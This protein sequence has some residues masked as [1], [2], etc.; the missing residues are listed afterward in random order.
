MPRRLKIKIGSKI[1]VIDDTGSWTVKNIFE[2]VFKDNDVKLK[3]IEGDFL[4]INEF[5]NN[6]IYLSLSYLIGKEYKIL[7]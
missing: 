4:E 2:V 3:F 6:D 7:S 5:K 1:E